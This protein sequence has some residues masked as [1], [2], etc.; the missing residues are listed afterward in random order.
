MAIRTAKNLH[1][2]PHIQPPCKGYPLS[3]YTVL[4]S[5]SAKAVSNCGTATNEVTKTIKFV[6]ERDPRLD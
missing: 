4:T 6:N 3:L 5:R 1:R 2:Y